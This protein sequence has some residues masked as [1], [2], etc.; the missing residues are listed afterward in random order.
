[1]HILGNTL[2]QTFKGELCFLVNF[3]GTMQGSACAQV[4]CSAMACGSVKFSCDGGWK[5]TSSALQ[6]EA[7][8]PWP[9]YVTHRRSYVSVPKHKAKIWA[10]QPKL[11][12]EDTQDKGTQSLIRLELPIQTL[13]CCELQKGQV[14]PGE[15]GLGEQN[16]SLITC[17]LFT[18]VI[19]R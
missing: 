17:V 13:A 9:S 18:A 1:M 5:E 14:I 8:G 10:I 15:P 11:P 4:L 12:P 7:W 6:T 16:V 2:L 19:T 3:T